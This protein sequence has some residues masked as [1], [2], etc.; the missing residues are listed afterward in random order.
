MNYE[1]RS[2]CAILCDGGSGGGTSAAS[3]RDC[4]TKTAEA[5]VKNA[6]KG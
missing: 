3:R 5:S 2:S 1:W 6:I 4:T